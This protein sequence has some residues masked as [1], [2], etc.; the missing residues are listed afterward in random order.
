MAEE[1]RRGEAHE[2]VAEGEPEIEVRVRMYWPPGAGQ[3]GGATIDWSYP[4]SLHG[5]A[6]THIVVVRHA[7]S[8]LLD[9]MEGLT[10]M[11]AE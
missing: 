7:I 5:Q 2:G 3:F 6:L 4:Q 1:R 11:D 9:H 10:H 8:V